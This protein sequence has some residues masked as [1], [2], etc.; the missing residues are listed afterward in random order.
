[1]VTS[2]DLDH[3]YTASI[4]KPKYIISTDPSD[5]M[6]V[7]I[8]LQ[9][10]YKEYLCSDT[11]SDNSQY[12]KVDVSAIATIANN[13]PVDVV[14]LVKALL[15]NKLLKEI[16]LFE[17]M[18]ELS[19][20]AKKLGNNK[21][22]FISYLM[23]KSYLDMK[24]FCWEGVLQEFVQKFP[25][26][27]QLVIALCVPDDKLGDGENKLYIYFYMLRHIQVHFTNVL[28]IMLIHVLLDL[29]NKVLLLYEI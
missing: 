2:A 18:K 29:L 14:K 26:L 4:K 6:H 28:I 16:L 15:N 11:H 12:K 19:S 27:L 25:T 10:S 5:V 13:A 21:H 22:G 20:Q 8:K 1:M 3:S 23:S 24:N 17:L 7:F 9:R